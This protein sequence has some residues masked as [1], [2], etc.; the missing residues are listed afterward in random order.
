MPI[1]SHRIAPAPIIL[2]CG[3]CARK[4]NCG[5]GRKGREPLKSVLRAAMRSATPR[6]KFRFIETRCLG[7]CPKRAV[8]AINTAQPGRIVAIP[9][10]T[11]AADALLALLLPGGL[12]AGHGP[13]ETIADPAVSI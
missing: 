5:F 9:A 7:I 8:A 1:A 13:A 4:L 12:P 10:K 11:Q 6:A 2:T 3:K